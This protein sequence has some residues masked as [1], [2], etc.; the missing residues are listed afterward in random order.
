M[1]NSLHAD[2]LYD[3]LVCGDAQ[4]T[5]AD[6][7][8]MS[9]SDVSKLLREEYGINKYNTKWGRGKHNQ[10]GKYPNLSYDDICAFIDSGSMDLDAWLGGSDGGYYEEDYDDGYDDSYDD[11][12]AE[13]DSYDDGYDADDSYDS[14]GGGGNGGYSGGNYGNGGGY[15]APQHGSSGRRVTYVNPDDYT[16]EGPARSNGG[17]KVTYVNPDDYDD[18]GNYR[19]SGGGMSGS[20][21]G[22][23]LILG[24]IILA[25]GWGIKKLADSEN[26]F[27]LYLKLLWDVG[28]LWYGFIPGLIYGFFNYLGTRSIGAVL[29]NH[30]LYT[31]TGLG[32][33][34]AGIVFFVKYTAF[35]PALIL[36]LLGLI[37]GFAGYKLFFRG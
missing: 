6:N 26:L 33:V 34:I 23:L 25:A 3:Y 1:A 16:Y 13:D 7:Y 37:I 11:G 15:Q 17:R 9:Q 4:Q 22:L 32:Y 18:D 31:W 27:G 19:G 20:A 36:V 24:I 5:I 2:I 30:A 10:A 35:F 8:G 12:Y 28:Y 21:R 29:T 14:N